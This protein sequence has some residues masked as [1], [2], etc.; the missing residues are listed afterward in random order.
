[1]TV[2]DRL[3]ELRKNKKK[4]QEEVADLLDV[5]RQAISKW[6]SGQTNPDLNNII[7][8]CEIYGVS[9][10]YLLNGTEETIGVSNADSSPETPKLS[11]LSNHNK[12]LLVK[13]L[14]Y[15]FIFGAVSLIGCLLIYGLC[16]I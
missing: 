11:I 2:A 15:I 13:S 12:E 3:Y 7:K 14:I 5:S 10:D 8:I 16:L 9:T 6:E 4:S 1:M